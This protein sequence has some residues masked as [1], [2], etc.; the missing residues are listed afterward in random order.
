MGP[1]ATHPLPIS[2]ASDAAKLLDRCRSEAA[3]ILCA[4]G[5][6]GLSASHPLPSSTTR[7]RSAMLRAPP[8]YLPAHEH[9]GSGHC[10][11]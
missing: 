5:T 7:S 6:R 11:R 8:A 4:K 2:R 3:C 1:Y 10:E 9:V